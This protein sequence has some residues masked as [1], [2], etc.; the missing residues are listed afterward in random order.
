MT[1]KSHSRKASS[2][3]SRFKLKYSTTSHRSDL[4]DF[5]S[6][7]DPIRSGLSHE[8]ERRRSM[9]E[10]ESSEFV[11]DSDE[12]QKDEPQEDEPLPTRKYPTCS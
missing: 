1:S 2:A 10:D 7:T 8:L 11:P 12:V 9:E 5:D 4:R 3:S 6:K